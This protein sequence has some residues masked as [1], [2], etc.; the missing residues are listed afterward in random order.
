[1]A[2]PLPNNKNYFWV[3]KKCDWQLCV[4]NSDCIIP[5]H[6]CPNC[7]SEVEL[8]VKDSNTLKQMAKRITNIFKKLS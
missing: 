3:C 1:M 6:K 2:V 4:G 8:V 7:H 5:C